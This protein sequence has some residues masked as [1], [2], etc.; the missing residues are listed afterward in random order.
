MRR[1]GTDSWELRVYAGTDPETRRQRWLTK[2]VHGSARYARS[3][4][5]EFVAEAGRARLR[6]STLSD[7]L[8]H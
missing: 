5:Q 7:L 3:Q 4:L 1:R 6:A 2:T 8:E